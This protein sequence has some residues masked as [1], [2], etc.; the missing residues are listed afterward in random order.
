MSYLAGKIDVAV[1]GAGH[2]GVEAAFACA[3]TGLDTILFTIN[4]DGISVMAC[5]PAIGGSA[6]GHLVR[7]VDA[8]GG[9]MGICADETLLQMKM[10]KL[11][12][13]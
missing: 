11:R 12:S 2:A 4:M 1:V 5:N 6:K 8:L 7:E 13:L 3:H 9:M 10:L